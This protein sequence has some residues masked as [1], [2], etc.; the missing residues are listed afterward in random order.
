VGK[1][2]PYAAS[3]ATVDDAPV[4]LFVTVTLKRG[5]FADVGL[6]VPVPLV[7][8]AVALDPLVGTENVGLAAAVDDR[9][10]V[11][12]LACVHV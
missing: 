8:T 1:V 2:D 4:K 6:V 12:P 11:R 7:H 9:A 3:D 10:V 5:Q